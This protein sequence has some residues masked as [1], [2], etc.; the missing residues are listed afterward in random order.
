[1]KICV[2]LLEKTIYLDAVTQ[3]MLQL[4]R[5][6]GVGDGVR[7]FPRSADTDDL[8]GDVLGFGAGAEQSCCD[9]NGCGSHWF[10]SSLWTLVAAASLQNLNQ[11]F[12]NLRSKTDRNCQL[13]ARE[14]IRW[15]RKH[16]LQELP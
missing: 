7:L 14:V 13:I 6:A 12:A 15:A 5:A 10:V 11:A 1:M 9:Q 3:E 8:F 4:F 2:N 16:P